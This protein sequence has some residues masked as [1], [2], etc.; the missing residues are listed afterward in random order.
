MRDFAAVTLLSILPTLAF[1]QTMPATMPAAPAAVS[2][3]SSADPDTARLYQQVRKSLVAVQ[4]TWE[5]ELGRH[6][7]I[8]AGIVVRDDG[9]VM[10]PMAV[11]DVRIPDEQ[12]KAFKILVPSDRGDAEEI[13]AKFLGR[14]ERSD[15]AFLQ[16]TGKH[17]WQ[18]LHFATRDLQIGQPLWSIG[19]LPKLA[20]YKAYIVQGTVAAN[21]RGEMPQILIS[22]PLAGVGSPVVDSSG[23]A[24]GMVPFQTEQPLLLNDRK[25]GLSMISRPPVYFVSADAVLGSITDPPAGQPLK[26]P[27]IGVMQLIGLKK[28][29]ADYFGLADRPAIQI[30]DIIPG[31]PAEQAGLTPGSIITQIDGKPLVRGDEVEELPMILRRQLLQMKVGTK[32][33]FT[34]LD[35]RT[36]K[37]RDITITLNERPKPANLAERFFAED[38]GFGVREMVFMDTYMRHLAANS[39]GVVVSVIRPQS[40]AQTARLE[41]NDLVVELNGKA[42][43]VT[44]QFTQDYRDFRKLR[45][46][47]AVVLV[48]L[49][50]GRNQTIRIEP[51]Q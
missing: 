48:V 33:V 9:L 8:G 36:R 24:V 32:V 45:P 4:Y 50:E 13:D 31:A 25:A 37:S 26:L 23:V 6:E 5:S 22:G 34:V 20:G 47:E 14:D 39:P 43:T 1:A 30:G 12:M 19:V 49:R 35:P 15:V 16:A 7:V 11:F 27:W 17:S 21:L 44:K 2:A 28:E 38:L 18:S 3:D 41:S 10:A 46:R 29:V 51:P 40:A 42:M